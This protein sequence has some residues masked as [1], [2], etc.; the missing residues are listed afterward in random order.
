MYAY[1]QCFAF[2]TRWPNVSSVVMPGQELW[3]KYHL[4][5]ACFRQNSLRTSHWMNKLPCYSALLLCWCWQRNTLPFN[6]CHLHPLIP[7]ILLVMSS[8]LKLEVSIAIGPCWSWTSPVHNGGP[9][10]AKMRGSR[11]CW[12]HGK[13]RCYL[14]LLTYRMVIHIA[15]G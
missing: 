9:A 6:P 12:Y 13:T 3:L 8:L 2:L 10:K 14:N 7:R 5:S 11:P 1:L 4:I 15:K